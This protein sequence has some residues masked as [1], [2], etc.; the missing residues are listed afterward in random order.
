MSR[1]LPDFGPAA[2]KLALGGMS[3]IGEL[4]ARLG[5]LSRYDRLGDVV[6]FDDFCSDLGAWEI[7]TSGAG[8]GV[9]VTAARKVS[10]G[11]SCKMTAGST[12]LRY[13]GI[14]GRFPVPYSVM[15]G[16]EVMATP[17][18]DIDYSDLM[19]DVYTGSYHMT[20]GIRFG[21]AAAEN[22]YYN[23]AGGWTIIPGGLSVLLDDHLFVMVKFT[24]NISTQK[25]GRLLI[26]PRTFDLSACS[27][28][29][30]GSAEFPRMECWGRT[31]SLPATNAVTYI[32]NIIVTCNDI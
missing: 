23:A 27:G 29:I 31:Y 10:G 6:F 8:S 19:V 32:D 21:Y 4:A 14:R 16:L 3:D 20:F 30:E 12:L 17:H 28:F 7:E 25:Y 5:A 13:A 18:A 9:M 22:Y 11:F 26:P 24:F 2:V 1:G 15:Y